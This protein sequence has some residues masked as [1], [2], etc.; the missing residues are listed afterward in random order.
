MS[1]VVLAVVLV[2]DGDDDDGCWLE[3]GGPN[4]SMSYLYVYVNVAVF[5]SCRLLENRRRRRRGMERTATRLDVTKV[6]SWVTVP[7]GRRT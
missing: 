1:I 7:F 5:S 4:I 3:T 2:V 6:S